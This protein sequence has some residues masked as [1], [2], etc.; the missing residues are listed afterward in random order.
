MYGREI[1]AINM[2]VRSHN[3]PVIPSFGFSKTS[4]HIFIV[5][6]LYRLKSN[7]FITN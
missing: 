2:L 5:I 6:T 4:F 7:R 1:K 3:K